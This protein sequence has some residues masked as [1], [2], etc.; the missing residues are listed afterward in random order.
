MIPGI[1]TSVC[2]IILHVLHT[3]FLATSKWELVHPTSTAEPPPRC[4]HTAVCYR[5]SM[6]VYG[7]LNGSSA[8]DDLWELNLGFCFLS[9]INSLYNLTLRNS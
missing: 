9:I 2:E 8:L 5:N 3:Y 4:Y 6:Y 7:G 1:L